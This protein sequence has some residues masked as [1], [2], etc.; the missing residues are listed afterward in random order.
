MCRKG[1]RVMYSIY[2][3]HRDAKYW[4]E[5]NAFK[6]ER[7]AHGVKHDRPPLT[8]IPFGGG[9]RNCIGAAFAQVESKLVLA[10]ILKNF[11]LTLLNHDVTTYMGATLEP[12]PGVTMRVVKR[13]RP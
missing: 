3:A 8:Y 1:T 13:N 2:L 9:P 4:P 7:F 11:D 6:P 12:R 10:A 5:P